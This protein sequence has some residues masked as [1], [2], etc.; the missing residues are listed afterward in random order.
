MSCVGAGGSRGG[1]VTVCL[2]GI[3]LSPLVHGHTI[4][5]VGNIFLQAFSSTDCAGG[6]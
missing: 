1:M 3:S 4:Q 5:A 6:Q 2:I